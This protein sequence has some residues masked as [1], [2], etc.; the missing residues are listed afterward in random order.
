MGVRCNCRLAVWLLARLF[1]RARNTPRPIEEQR[2]APGIP[3]RTTC[4]VLECRIVENKRRTQSRPNKLF[5]FSLSPSLS[6]TLSRRGDAPLAPSAWHIS[7]WKRA[8]KR[9]LRS[10][11][12]FGRGRIKIFRQAVI[13][14]PVCEL[15]DGCCIDLQDG[16]PA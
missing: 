4:S 12:S 9:G 10:F 15:L 14:F 7:W 1:N 8:L 11:N 2:F 6:R 13:E 5:G 3:N 16:C